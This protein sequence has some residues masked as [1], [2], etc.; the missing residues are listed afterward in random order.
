LSREGEVGKVPSPA[1]FK[2]AER[3]MSDQGSARELSKDA[4]L[5]GEVQVHG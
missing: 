1:D 5:E 3:E 4:G 2:E